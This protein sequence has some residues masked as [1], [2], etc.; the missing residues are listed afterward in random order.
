MDGLIVATG[1][2]RN[3]ILLA[4]VTAKLVRDWVVHGRTTFNAEAFSPMRFRENANGSGVDSSRGSG[5]G[6]SR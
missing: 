1:H 4:A 3:G 5:S 2:F 6:K